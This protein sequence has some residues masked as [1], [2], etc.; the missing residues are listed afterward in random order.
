ML[1]VLKIIQWIYLCLADEITFENHPLTNERIPSGW[2]P[3]L[4]L[5]DR[6]VDLEFGQVV[7]IAAEHNCQVPLFK[8]LG[9]DEG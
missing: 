7:S 4:F 5:F 9:I 3:A 2:Q 8:L 1:D 6:P